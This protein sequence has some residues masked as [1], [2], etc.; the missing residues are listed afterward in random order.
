M[1]DYGKLQEIEILYNKA[2]D[3]GMIPP[4]W[5]GSPPVDPGTSSRTA[6]PAA[7]STTAPKSSS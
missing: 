3:Y 1:S 7:T 2:V 6:K 4:D 5:D